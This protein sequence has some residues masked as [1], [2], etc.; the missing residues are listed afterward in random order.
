[1][2]RR[3]YITD[4]WQG[5]PELE[6]GI[7]GDLA[8]VTALGAAHE[9]E[10]LGTIDDADAL[11][12]WHDIKLSE[13]SIDALK[14]CKAIVRIGVGFD[15]V[16]LQHARQR[17]I[18]VCNVP[19]YGVEEVADH[20]MA[21]LLALVRNLPEFQTDLRRQPLHWDARRGR[22]TPRLRGKVL[23]IIGVGRIGSAVALRGKAFGLDVVGHD[24]YVPDGRGKSLGMRMVDSRAELLGQSDFVS[25]HT[26]LTD[27]T[28]G[29]IDAAE[30]E[31]FKPGSILVNTARG[32]ICDTAALLAA[33]E[34]EKLYGVGL[35]VFPHEPPHEDPLVGASR[36][37]GHVASYRCVLT[38]H[39][40]FYSE[41]SFEE[42]RT[43]AAH[44]VGRALR[45]EPLRNVVNGVG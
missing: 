39:A 29:M 20:T 31:H 34:T 15:N 25:I 41:E 2:S 21:L 42:M 37:P 6:Q 14:H 19:D 8:D 30:L 7:L 1:M 4:F 9:D 23:G 44:E 16:P 36:R 40:A 18:P 10:L 12:V 13:R 22:R 5:D 17:G 33:L 45:G 32:P 35:D 27:E 3:V 26:P 38:P 24:P 43:K 11:L 28:R